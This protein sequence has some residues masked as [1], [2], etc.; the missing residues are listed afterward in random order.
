[1]PS[2]LPHIRALT[3]AVVATATAPV[4]ATATAPVIAAAAGCGLP[5]ES[6]AYGAMVVD[7]DRAKPPA[8]APDDAVFAGAARLERAALIQ[9]VLD[10]NPDV[11][12]AR[13][14]WRAALAR[15]PQATTWDD[16]MVS[17]SLAPLS[18]AGSAPFGQAVQIEERLP[19]PG[20]RR[21]AGQVALAEAEAARGQVD[22]ARLRLAEMASTLFDDYWVT[23]RSLAINAQHTE[24]VAGLKRAA[25]AQYAAARG[26]AQDSLEAETELVRLDH[27]RVMLEAGRA[28]A[29]AG[30]NGLLHRRPELALPPPPDVL[31]VPAEPAA[32]TTLEDEAVTARPELAVSR[33]Q[34]R[35]RKAAVDLAH[36]DTYPRI[37]VMARY[38]S[39][40][41]MTEHQWMVG[42]SFALPVMRG[43]RDA[44]VAGAEASSARAGLEYDRD[45]DRIRVEV[46]QAYERL[47]AARHLL[48]LYDDRLVPAARD[49]VGAARADFV[50]AKARFSEVIAAERTLRD[51]ELGREETMADVSR[52]TAALDR[53]VG[54]MPGMGGAR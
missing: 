43:T 50:T 30:L 33:A 48:G 34:V 51:A 13:E 24:L 14:A 36:R 22:T 11:A 32:M 6:R 17:Y 52:L 12:A 40:R 7:Y 25:E 37:G 35:A 15:Y 31:D 10:R 5:R 23:T 28:V 47:M 3:W 44:A 27:D 45:V 9:A 2:R 38:D 29:V 8:A 49:R 18:I 21:L 46:A 4:I 54:R 16:P 42:L 19:V 20:R 1:M 39:M 41:P 26:S 53:A